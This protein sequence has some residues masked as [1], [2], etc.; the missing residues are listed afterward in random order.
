MRRALPALTVASGMVAVAA[1]VLSRPIEDIGASLVGF[2][3]MS[4]LALA[5]VPCMHLALD[6]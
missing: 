2:V 3:L 6:P 5:M 4:V 1:W